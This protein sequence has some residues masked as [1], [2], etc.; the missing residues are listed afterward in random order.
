M[1]LI[2]PSGAAACSHGW[3]AVRRQSDEAEPVETSAPFLPAP[4]GQRNCPTRRRLSL[5]R[6][7]RRTRSRP[8]LTSNRLQE[9]VDYRDGR[10]DRGYS[11]SMGDMPL[12]FGTLGEDEVERLCKLAFI[13]DFVFRSP[14]YM[15]GN[16]EKE[17]CDVLILVG[18]AAIL[19]EVK[20][21]DLTIAT[22][23]PRA[24]AH[25]WCNSKAQEAFKQIRGGIAALQKN[26]VPAVTNAWQGRVDLHSRHIRSFYAIAAVHTPL[27][28]EYSIVPPRY[29]TTHGHCDVVLV[30]FSELHHLLHELSTI[31]DL[32]DYFAM[33]AQFIHRTATWPGRELDMLAAFKTQYPKLKLARDFGLSV[34]FARDIWSKYATMPR[35]RYRDSSNE[36]SYV[37]DQLIEE[38]HTCR[39]YVPEHLH[40]PILIS[41]RTRIGEYVSVATELSLLRRIERRVIGGRILQKMHLCDSSG[42]G[43]HFAHQAHS[44]TLFLFRVSNEDR[45]TRYY[46]MEVLARL[47]VVNL[48]PS[49]I[50]AITFNSL[51]HIESS[52]DAIMFVPEGSQTPS[53][54]DKADFAQMFNMPKSGKIA[55]FGPTKHPPKSRFKTRKRRRH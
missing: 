26:L 11:A 12:S 48:A 18:D 20:T 25:S 21:P 13:R 27:G 36:S 15:R 47:L 41:D 24:R 45:R 50:V 16:A 40:D 54:Q 38:L 14:K 22:K 52:I 17:L 33:R 7:S 8:P 31:G 23:W 55:E 5:T 46:R 42:R 43:R 39:D 1:H 3:S 10:I 35:R 32:I 49:K 4:E 37:V 6:T 51:G 28:F 34:E 19:V 2:G 30:N 44:R 29:S 53:A 9:P